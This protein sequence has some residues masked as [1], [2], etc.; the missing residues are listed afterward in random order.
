MLPLASELKVL[1]IGSKYLVVIGLRGEAPLKLKGNAAVIPTSSFYSLRHLVMAA[2]RAIR[3]FHHGVN[4]SDNFAYELGICLLGVKEVSKVMEELSRSNS[5]YAFVS[6]C[7]ELEGCL[8]PLVSLLMRGFTPAE[9]VPR[10]EPEKLPSCTGN[11]E[12]LA[13][14]QGIVVELER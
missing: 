6:Y 7:D 9:V 13:M 11:Y 2:L 8:R 4:I 5:E 3:A 1:R 10:Y 12:C 14:E